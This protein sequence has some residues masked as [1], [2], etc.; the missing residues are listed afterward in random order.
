MR[1]IPIGQYLVEN[2]LITQQQLENILQAQREAQGQKRFGDVIVELG[3]MSEV[4]FAQAL[5]GKL[6]VAYV[7][8]DRTEI[9]FEAVSKIPESLAKKHT[10]IAIN[11][12]GK[13]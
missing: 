7:D 4:R 2:N 11:I 12:Q 1:N 10:V 3:Y 9:D 5:A 6:K 8:L 13:D